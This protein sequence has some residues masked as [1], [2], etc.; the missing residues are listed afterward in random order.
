MF[1]NLNTTAR[2]NYFKRAYEIVADFSQK[3]S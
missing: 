2:G 3:I 1:V